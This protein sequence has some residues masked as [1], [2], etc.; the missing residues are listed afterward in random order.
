MDCGL[1]ARGRT[2]GITRNVGLFLGYP[3]AYAGMAEGENLRHEASADTR[4]PPE[5][6]STSPNSCQVL[7]SNLSNCIC[8]IG[9]KSLALVEMVMPGKSIGSF[10]PWMLAA[11]FITF[12]RVRLSPH[13]SSTATMACVAV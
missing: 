1:A 4:H 2:P 12:S 10:R 11:C 7:P 5:P 13:A 8:L 3:P 9:A 6:E